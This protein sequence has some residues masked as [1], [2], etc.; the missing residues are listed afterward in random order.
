VNTPP[1]SSSTPPP[2]ST[3][4]TGPGVSA[5]DGYE[6]S[7][8]QMSSAGRNISTKAEDSK[9]DVDEVKPAKVTAPEFGVKHQDWQTDYAAAIEAMGTASLAMCDNLMAFSQQLGDAG[10]DY[11][12]NET[13][14]TTTVTQSGSG[15]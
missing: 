4:N 2:S 3:S 6:T 11:A 13:S 1:P 5:P 12:T 14:A 8:G 10:K 9:G 15:M 7:T